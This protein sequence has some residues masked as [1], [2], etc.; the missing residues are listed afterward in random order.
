MQHATSI[1]GACLWNLDGPAF[2][3]YLP[4]GHFHNRTFLDGTEQF[5]HS[6]KEGLLTAMTLHLDISKNLPQAPRI[7]HHGIT[8]VDEVGSGKARTP[9][10]ERGMIEYQAYML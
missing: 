10:L 4:V 8:M 6:L 7:P 2:V 1:V 3:Q 5:D 9:L